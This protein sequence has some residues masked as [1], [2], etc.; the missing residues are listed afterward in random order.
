MSGFDSPVY[1]MYSAVVGSAAYIVKPLDPVK[2]LK[3]VR[4]AFLAAD[5]RQAV[6]G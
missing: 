5:A 3:T 1:R 2:V 4:E 6:R